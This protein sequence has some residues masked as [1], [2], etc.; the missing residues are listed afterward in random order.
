MVAMALPRKEAGL[1]VLEQHFRLGEFSSGE[2]DRLLAEGEADIER[3]D[4]HDGEEV[5]REIDQ[6]S[7]ARRQNSSR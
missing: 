7:A 6:L 4:V 1:A 3:G 2:L 5:F